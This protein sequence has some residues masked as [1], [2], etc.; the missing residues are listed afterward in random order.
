[1]RTY[2]IQGSKLSIMWFFAAVNDNEFDLMLLKENENGYYSS[3]DALKLIA[4]V[5][6]VP[7]VDNR[8]AIDEISYY[9]K[10]NVDLFWID[11]TI[12]NDNTLHCKRGAVL[13][14]EKNTTSES[15]YSHTNQPS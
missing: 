13:H 5:L 1:M 9:D 12:K 6:S 15:D 8:V 11:I 14:A 2:K 3:K 4:Q 10:D 7:I